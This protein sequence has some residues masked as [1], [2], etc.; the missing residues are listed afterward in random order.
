M[1]LGAL[2]IIPQLYNTQDGDKPIYHAL[3]MK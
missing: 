3:E 2:T 1:K